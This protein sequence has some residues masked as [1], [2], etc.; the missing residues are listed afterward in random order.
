MF[1]MD[2]VYYPHVYFKYTFSQGQHK[3]TKEL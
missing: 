1:Y 3:E 2:A